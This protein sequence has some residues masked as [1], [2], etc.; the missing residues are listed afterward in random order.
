MPSAYMKR[1]QRGEKKACIFSQS[2]CHYCVS[3]SVPKY[4]GICSA[5]LSCVPATLSRPTLGPEERRGGRCMATRLGLIKFIPPNK[6]MTSSVIQ[7]GERGHCFPAPARKHTNLIIVV[8]PAPI[9]VPVAA[10]VVCSRQGEQWGCGIDGLGMGRWLLVLDRQPL[11][12]S[13]A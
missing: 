7:P 1:H 9:T 6:G 2:R 11:G 13:E 12:T 10:Q 8:C 4:N 3:V 5:D